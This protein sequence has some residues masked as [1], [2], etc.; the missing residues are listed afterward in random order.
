M[1]EWGC[2]YFCDGLLGEGI[3]MQSKPMNQEQS[4][5]LKLDFFPRSAE[6]LPAKAI[7]TRLVAPE[8]RPA[9]LMSPCDARFC[10]CDCACK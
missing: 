5:N 7:N 1:V 3:Q 6:A 4:K 9:R 8:T 2:A 10:Q